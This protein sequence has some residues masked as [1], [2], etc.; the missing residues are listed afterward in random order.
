[1]TFTVSDFPDG[2]EI[3][4]IAIDTAPMK[5]VY[6]LSWKTDDVSKPQLTKTQIYFRFKT[7]K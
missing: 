6:P 3:P 2:G 4:R 1:M 7:G 5:F